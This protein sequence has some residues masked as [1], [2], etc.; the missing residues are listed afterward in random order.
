M[1]RVHTAVF[2]KVNWYSIN[3][4]TTMVVTQGVKINQ[5]EAIRRVIRLYQIEIGR[6]ENSLE[7]ARWG[8]A[9]SRSNRTRIKEK[10]NAS[11]L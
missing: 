10:I 5:R 8:V 3:S 7:I 4:V 2:M 6:V 1:L 11:A 9:I